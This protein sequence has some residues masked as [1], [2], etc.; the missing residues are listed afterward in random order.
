V[1]VTLI[2]RTDM[3]FLRRSLVGLFLL[4]LTVGLLAWAGDTF[5]GAVQVRNEQDSRPRVPRER[6]FAANVVLVQPETVTPV[7]T[8]FGEVR[9][10]RT[11]DLRT[12][13][14]GMIVELADG[15]E[16]GGNVVAGQLLARIDPLDARVSVVLAATDLA[17]AEAELRDAER[18]IELASDELASARDQVRLREQALTRQNDLLARGVG[19]GPAVENAELAVS[20]AKQAVLSRRGALAN[21]QARIDQALTA[22]SRRKI[23]MTE[24]ERTLAETEIYAG[25]SGTLA[26]VSVVQGGLVTN[27]ERLAQIIDTAALE[28]TFRVS[29][30]QYLRLLDDDGQLLLSDVRVSLDIFGVDLTTAGRIT[31]ESAV[32]GDG[33][34]GR[35]LFARIAEA[36]GFRPGDFVTVKIDEPPLENVVLLPSSALDAGP[37][38]LVVDEEDRLQVVA[39]ELLRRQGDDV[40]IRASGLAGKEVVSERSPLLGAGIKIK[41]IRAGGDGDIVAVAAEPEM[42]ELSDERRATLV[43]FIQ[44]NKRMPAEARERVLAQLRQA[45]VPAQVVER[46]E[47]RMGG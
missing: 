26:E 36:K 12:T 32:V 11:L 14:G 28:V 9:S 24:A 4:S 45:K 40:I 39:V 43:A 17:E 20:S 46:I 5:Y 8:S 18:S 42:L 6:V 3:R 35:L 1:A 41:P 22:R 10:R 7:L 47:S 2:L 38:V 25:F 21:A 15:F 37:S 27:N 13:T 44:S 30:P 31:R 34:T 16:E 23:N 19:T 29:T 33:Q